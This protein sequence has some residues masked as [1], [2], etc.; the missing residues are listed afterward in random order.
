MYCYNDLGCIDLQFLTSKKLSWTKWNSRVHSF[1]SSNTLSVIIDILDKTTSWLSFH[2][3]HPLEDLFPPDLMMASLTW[4]TL[5]LVLFTLLIPYPL[6]VDYSSSLSSSSAS[7]NHFT[8]GLA[9][10]LTFLET[11]LDTYF[12]DTLEPHWI[13]VS[14]LSNSLS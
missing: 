10:L 7:F 2:R 4:L 1:V 12:L 3:Y 11:S 13:M 6:Y 5:L 14:S 8:K 9:A